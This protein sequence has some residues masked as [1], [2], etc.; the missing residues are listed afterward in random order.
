MKDKNEFLKQME[1]LQVPDVDPVKHQQMVKMAIMN[2]GR[3]AA[4]GVW[5]VIIPCYFLFCVFMYYFFHIHISWFEA[6]FN[7]VADLD[8]NPNTRFLSPLLLVGLPF[9]CLVINSL[10]IVHVQY[11]R[12]DAKRTKVNELMITLKLRLINILLILISLGIIGV[13]T[14]YVMTENI[15]ISIKK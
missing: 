8:K 13:F 11:V 14:A 1:S 15:S 10:A 5:L 6:M 7:L 2:A 12:V 3:S 4:L 9:V